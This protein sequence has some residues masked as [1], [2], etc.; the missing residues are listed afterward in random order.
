[1]E[2][3]L[4]WEKGRGLELSEDTWSAQHAMGDL[5]TQSYLVH[6]TLYKVNTMTPFQR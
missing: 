5:H 2:G 3:N 6:R 4:K 1:M